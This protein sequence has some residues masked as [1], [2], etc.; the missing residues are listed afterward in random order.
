[1]AIAFA[2]DKKIDLLSQVNF[3]VEVTGCECPVDTSVQRTEAPT[4]ATAEISNLRHP[5]LRRHLAVPKIFYALA[6]LK[7]LTAALR[8]ARFFVHRTRSQ[9]HP[10]Q[11]PALLA[12]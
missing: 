8:Y 4:E 12:K 7:I 3:L 9:P 10:K 1:M 6:R 11:A 5:R 2:M